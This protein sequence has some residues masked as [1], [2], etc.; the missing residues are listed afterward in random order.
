[1][2]AIFVTDCRAMHMFFVERFHIGQPTGPIILIIG[3]VLKSPPPVHG[4]NI[5]RLASDQIVQEHVLCFIS[6]AWGLA[7][8]P[9]IFAWNH[10]VV[11][12]ILVIV[13]TGKA[14]APMNHLDQKAGQKAVRVVW[15]SKVPHAT[16]IPLGIGRGVEIDFGGIGLANKIALCFGEQRQTRQN[17]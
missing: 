11:G 2:V 6:Y 12:I 9:I 7:I 1:M 14:I 3:T 17:G 5:P 16:I 4:K 10:V 15:A 13:V 8:I